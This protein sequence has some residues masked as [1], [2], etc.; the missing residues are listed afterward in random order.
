M[1]I[2]N[3]RFEDIEQYISLWVTQWYSDTGVN[4]SEKTGGLQR[5]HPFLML[6]IETSSAYVCV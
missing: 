2:E 1:G 3:N 5:T 6:G 4:C